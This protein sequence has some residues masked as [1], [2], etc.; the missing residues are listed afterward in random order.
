MNGAGGRTRTGTLL[1]KLDFESSASTNFA[2]PAGITG[3]I[4]LS[5][6]HIICSSRP[7][8]QSIYLCEPRSQLFRQFICF[9]CSNLIR[10]AVADFP[11][12]SY[13]QICLKY[14]S[15]IGIKCSKSTR[16]A[17]CPINEGNSANSVIT[18]FLTSASAISFCW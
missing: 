10:Q 11:R 2:T 13:S 16:K 8:A 14:D 17:S 1:P 9:Y 3:P 5:L 7:S 4:C 15:I 18:S 6:R 12:P